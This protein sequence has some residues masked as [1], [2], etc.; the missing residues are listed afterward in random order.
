[1]KIS[2]NVEA[3]KCNKKFKHSIHLHSVTVYRALQLQLTDFGDRSQYKIQSQ[4]SE[5]IA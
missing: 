1:M 4:I 3:S 5:K 2:Q